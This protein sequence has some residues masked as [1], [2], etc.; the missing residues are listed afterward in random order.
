MRTRAFF[1][2]LTALG[3]GSPAT[4]MDAPADD[5]RI[6]AA[7]SSLDLVV[8]S[9]A[10]HVD[11]DVAGLPAMPS[12]RFVTSALEQ[13]DVF[14]E[15]PP[16]DSTPETPYDDPAQ[17]RTRVLSDPSYWASPRGTYHSVVRAETDVAGIRVFAGPDIDGD[18]APDLGEQRCAGSVGTVSQC[19]FELDDVHP[20]YRWWLIVQ[21]VSG[22]ATE[23]RLEA[24]SL[25]VDCG[26]TC[27]L[28]ALYATGPGHVAAGEA[29]AIRLAWDATTLG[30]GKP[31]LGT[32]QI[33]YVPDNAVA[34]VPVRVVPGNVVSTPRRLGLE[35]I[36]LRPGR[37]YDGLFIDVPPGARSLSVE[38]FFEGRTA[39]DMEAQTRLVFAGPVPGG[40]Y[41][42]PPPDAVTVGVGGRI[43]YPTPG[44]YF[45]SLENTGDIP[46][47]VRVSA[48]IGYPADARTKL[49]P[50]SYYNVS[51][52]GHGVFVYPAGA[53]GALLWYT[54]RDDG[55]P[56][57]YYAQG[58]RTAGVPWVWPLYRAAWDG[59][60]RHLAPVG[61]IA[62]TPRT[63][64][65]GIS[66]T[67]D[68][69]GETGSEALKP[70]LR[71][72]GSLDGAPLDVNGHWFDPA[73]PG[74]GFSAQTHPDYEFIAGFLFDARG[75]PRFLAAE[76]G[77]AFDAAASPVP[78]YQLK[79]FA[80][81]AP[82]TSPV[83]T[84]VG[85][86]GRIYSG[87]G[88]E[89]IGVEAAFADGVPGSWSSSAPV[90]QLGTPVGCP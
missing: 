56:T 85:V 59:V 26:T 64:S 9:V 51:R 67:W 42:A 23:V 84:E 78:L 48:S 32:L 3:A 68:I 86:L 60:T 73:R 5:V 34:I 36:Y 2:L 74:Y 11:V 20:S 31:H 19:L 13:P 54:Y 18:G 43:D 88:I 4:A 15:T 90:Q 62:L 66:Y 50:G 27:P 40:P 8:K 17:V 47:K 49:V 1:V 22:E 14:V 44:R 57:W 80:P 37:R 87:A 25:Q 76:R 77:G 12:A 65:G 29:F 69:D 63:K 83:R 10:G 6:T 7:P 38:G 81:L 70:W 46:A 61:R 71:G 24:A 41:V 21:R 33:Q 16:V 55:T 30:F 72:C 28:G 39:D 82:W 53:D 79:G 89:H 35:R 58:P 52:P 45:Y 75:E